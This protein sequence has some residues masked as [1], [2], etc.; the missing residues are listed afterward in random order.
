MLISKTYLIQV[1]MKKVILMVLILVLYGCAESQVIKD[2]ISQEK[3]DKNENTSLALI[4]DEDK[5]LIENGKYVGMHKFVKIK[6]DKGRIE[7]AGDFAMSSDSIQSDLKTG[8][9]ISY[10][11]NTGEVKEKGKYE[12][13]KYLQCCFS[14]PCE[15][16]YNYKIGDWEYYYATGSLKA[17]GRYSVKSLKKGTSCEGGATLLFGLTDSLWNFYDEQ[18]QEIEVNDSIRLEY[19]KVYDGSFGGGYLIPNHKK[20]E[21]AFKQKN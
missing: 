17:K 3:I 19:E 11:I 12:I 13:G 6:D 1:N 14:G 2:R 9:W 8:E 18:E 5:Y 7:S 20:D 15:Q 4:L 16:Y 21:I 10:F